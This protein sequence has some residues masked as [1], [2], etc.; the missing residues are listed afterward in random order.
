[1]YG[2]HELDALL[3]DGTAWTYLCGESGLTKDKIKTIL[4]ATLFMKSL[5]FDP[6]CHPALK[7]PLVSRDD[8]RRFIRVK[9]LRA[10]FAARQNYI[11]N[12]LETVD[13]DA[14][15][16][17]LIASDY[18]VRLASISQSYELK[19]LREATSY[20]TSLK[21]NNICLWLHDGFFINGNS[22]KYSGISNNLNKIVDK[23]L[24]EHGFIS[25]VESSSP[26]SS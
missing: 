11:N 16:N 24:K 8:L 10:L 21:S 13:K 19:I 3:N 9:E 15:G 2:F 25:G 20:V 14:F 6:Y 26:L 12:G 7:N 1:M 23:S 4:Y 22:T 17:P 18:N 5:E